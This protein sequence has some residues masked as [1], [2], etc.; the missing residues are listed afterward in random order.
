MDFVAT[1][2]FSGVVMTAT[3]FLSDSSE[4]YFAKSK[5][6]RRLDSPS[7]SRNVSQSV[8]FLYSGGNP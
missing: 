8:G 5:E 1:A 3:S 7:E 4:K 2:C 6:I